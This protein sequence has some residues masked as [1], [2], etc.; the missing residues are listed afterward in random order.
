MRRGMP[1]RRATVV[2][3]TASGGATTAP[4]A[5]PAARVAPGTTH[6]GEQPD[7]GRRERDGADAEQP[8]RAAVGLEVDQRGADRCRVEQRRQQ[9]DQDEVGGQFDV[10]EV[11]DE[12]QPD[13]DRDEQQRFGPAEAAREAGDESDDRDE[14]EDVE[15]RVHPV[16]VQTAGYRR[17]PQPDSNACGQ[18][19]PNRGVRWHTEGM[20]RVRYALIVVLACA[21]RGCLHE[22]GRQSVA[23]PLLLDGDPAELLGA[24]RALQRAHDVAVGRDDGPERQARREA[25]DAAGRRQAEHSHLAPLAFAR[26]WIATLDW[27]YATM[28]TTLAR[29]HFRRQSCD[30]CA[31]FFERTSNNAIARHDT[32]KG[33]RLR[34]DR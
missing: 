34:S 27:A 24:D 21:V 17:V 20:R 26:Y 13:A 33:G 2:A 29:T 5:K 6:H 14:A 4:S 9:A 28:D 11:R 8:D 3:A 18:R 19:V 32:F 31:N 12:R 22:R 15:R 1:M 23:D 10:E 7:R 25:A 16:I 30:T